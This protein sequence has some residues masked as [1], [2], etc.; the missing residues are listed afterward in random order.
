MERKIKDLRD[1]I[2]YSII[3]YLDHRADKAGKACKTGRANKTLNPA[4]LIA[5][6][7]LL[8]L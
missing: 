5:L 6:P 3:I 7:V 8:D 2:S 4:G 1:T